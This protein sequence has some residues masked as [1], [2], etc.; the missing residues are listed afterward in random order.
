MAAARQYRQTMTSFGWWS[1]RESVRFARDPISKQAYDSQRVLEEQ[2]WREIDARWGLVTADDVLA[3]R[4]G[5][6]P[7]DMLTDHTGKYRRKHPIAPGELAAFNNT[8]QATELGHQLRVHELLLVGTPLYPER[9]LPG[10][11]FDPTGQISRT[12]AAVLSAVNA[13]WTPE[14]TALWLDAPN[15]WLAR[16][17]PADILA[18][19]PG[20]VLEA[21]NRALPTTT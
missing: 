10:F 11:Q 16:S 17:A 15:G 1:A 2:A 19:E 8:P 14:A 13:H 6:R 7:P 4:V 21:L 5:V 20:W 12:V 18:T 9:R 3:V